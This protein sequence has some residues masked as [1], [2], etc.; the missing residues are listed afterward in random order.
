MVLCT[1]K[2]VSILLCNTPL[3]VPEQRAYSSHTTPVAVPIPYYT[4]A[5]LVRNEAGAKHTE[6]KRLADMCAYF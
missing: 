5:I 6:C 3:H 1:C 2:K 4:A